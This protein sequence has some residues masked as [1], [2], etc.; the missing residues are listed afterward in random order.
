[1]YAVWEGDTETVSVLVEAGA[2]VNLQEN[3]SKPN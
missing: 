3:V 2:D 1:M